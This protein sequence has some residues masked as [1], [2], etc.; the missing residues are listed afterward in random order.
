MSNQIPTT[1]LQLRSQITRT[2]Q[3]EL[4]LVE[5]PNLVTAQAGR[6]D[7]VCPA[8]RPCCAVT[9]MSDPGPPKEVEVRS[10]RNII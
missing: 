1:G 10:E 2:G 4:S 3:L 9:R 8:S 6:G 5:G 7:P